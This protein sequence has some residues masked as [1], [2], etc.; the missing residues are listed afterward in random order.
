LA[1]LP[2]DE[3]VL[4]AASDLPVLSRAAIEE[5]LDTAVRSGA[6]LV[7]AC[8]ER[9][10]HETR[11]PGVPHTWARLRDGTYC[12]G[13]AVLLKPRAF[14]PLERFLGRLGAARKNPA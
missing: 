9:G 1:G 7:Y 12:G 13:G 10:R 11:F 2:P 8:V 6:D 4:V 5:F 14:T 3:L